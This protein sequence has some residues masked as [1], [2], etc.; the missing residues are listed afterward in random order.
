MATGVLEVL[1]AAGKRVP[2]DVAVVGFDDLGVAAGAN[3]PLTTVRNPVEDIAERGINLLLEQIE[4]GATG[5][6]PQKIR[7]G[8]GN[9]FMGATRNHMRQPAGSPPQG[10]L[11]ACGRP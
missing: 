6:R 7:S 9:C 1:A 2:D 3:P 11:M 10:K 5:G 4:T 8:R